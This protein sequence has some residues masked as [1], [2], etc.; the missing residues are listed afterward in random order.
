MLYLYFLKYLQTSPFWSL[1]FGFHLIYKSSM[2]LMLWRILPQIF[3]DFFLQQRGRCLKKYI[4]FTLFTPR[5]GGEGSWNLQFLV[6]LPY[7]CYKFGKDWP[8]RSWVED[9]NRCKRQK[10][11]QDGLK[12]IAIGL[13]SDSGNLKILG[14]LFTIKK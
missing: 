2:F 11:H 3:N 13:L 8:N 1:D 9:V 12:L 7:K 10:S 14:I 5:D 6:S 4:N